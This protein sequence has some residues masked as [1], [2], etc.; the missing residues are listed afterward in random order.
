MVLRACFGDLGHMR[1]VWWHFRFLKRGR[2]WT[3]LE[4]SLANY[5]I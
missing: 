5:M 1:F 3:T 4:F 2:V